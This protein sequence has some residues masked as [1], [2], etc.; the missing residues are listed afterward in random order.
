MKSWSEAIPERTYVYPPTPIQ[1]G[2]REAKNWRTAAAN[3]VLHL[4]GYDAILLSGRE[5]Q[6]ARDAGLRR[7]VTTLEF[8]K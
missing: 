3:V 5:L 7:V 8:F 1:D 6:K 4:L 2:W